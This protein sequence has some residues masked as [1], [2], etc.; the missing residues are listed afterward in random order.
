MLPIY[1][2]QPF[3]VNG[4][5]CHGKKTPCA[6]PYAGLTHS[7]SRQQR[8]AVKRKYPKL[9]RIREIFMSRPSGRT[10]TEL[11]SVILE[12]AFSIHAEGS[13]LAKFGN[14]HVLCTASI[15]ERVPPFLRNTGKG[16][17]TAEYG[18]LPRSTHS[19]SER[20]ATRGKQG[21]RTLEIQ[22]LIGRSLRAVTDLEALGERQ[23]KIDCDVIQADGGTRTASITGAWVALRLACDRLLL[24]GLITRQPLRDQVS[25]IS[26]GVFEGKPILD[27]DYDEDSQA[28]V[29]ANFIL[30]AGE[31]LVEI[32]A[33][34]EERPFSR[35]ELEQMLD[36]AEQGCTTLFDLQITA[37]RAAAP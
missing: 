6:G 2:M 25:A 13:C 29:D 7:N 27:L 19:R 14:T 9:V 18:M 11:R 31:G 24:D 5:G 21:G 3:A 28:E 17:V 20:E 30:S 10:A 4:A 37:V 22:R 26:C 33:T 12:P 15:D 23:I 1:G 34:G 35:V 32:Q 16:W 8:L 36:L